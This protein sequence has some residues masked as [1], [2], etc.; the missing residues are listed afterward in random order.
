MNSRQDQIGFSIGDIFDPI[1]DAWDAAVDVF[2]SVVDRIPGGEWARDAVDQGATWLVDFAKSD[3]GFWTLGVIS[4][5]A[6]GPL[7]YI[8]GPQVASVVWATP[9]VLKGD[10]FTEAYTKELI[11]RIEGLIEYFIGREGPEVTKKIVREF[12]DGVKAATNSPAF[13]QALADFKNSIPNLGSA[14]DIR[15]AL[16]AAGLDPQQ[17]AAKLQEEFPGLRADQVALAI[18]ANFH[19]MIYA[20]DREFTEDTGRPRVYRRL[21]R[22][23]PALQFNPYISE[24]RLENQPPVIG[25]FIPGTNVPAGGRYRTRRPNPNV[26]GTG[27]FEV[28]PSRTSTAGNLAIAAVLT[29]PFWGP[30]AATKFKAWRRK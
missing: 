11:N 12:G 28:N 24:L 13:K 29:A 20:V 8:T 21:G 26:L 23:K 19:Q 22:G 5:N 4:S 2:T 9:G 16:T 30:W 17:L 6:Y 7:A 3:I 27:N 14:D 25:N 1:V 15:R 10:S 18:N